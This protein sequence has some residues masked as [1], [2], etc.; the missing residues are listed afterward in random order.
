MWRSYPKSSS[1]LPKT[2]ALLGKLQ[3]RSYTQPDASSDGRAYILK[4]NAQ[5][6]ELPPSSGIKPAKPVESH[7]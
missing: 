1:G 5:N 4:E 7:F 6:K 3:I 2:S